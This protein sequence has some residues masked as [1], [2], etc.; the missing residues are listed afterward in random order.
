MPVGLTKYRDKLPHLRT[1]TAE[2]AGSIIDYIEARQ[3]QILAQTGTRFV[4]AADE[5]YV[6][7]DR[8]FPA[9][10][11]YEEMS[12]FENGIGMA[13]EFIT[14]FNRRR[15]RLS[16]LKADRKALF[17]TGHSAHPFLEREIMPYIRETLKLDLTFAPV[18]N[19]FWGHSVTVSGLLTGNDLLAFAQERIDN[20]DAVVLPFAVV[21]PAVGEGRVS[22][23]VPAAVQ[24]LPLVAAPVRAP[25]CPQT[26]HAVVA[27]VP[28]VG[29]ALRPPVHSTAVAYANDW[30]DTKK[31][32]SGL[33]LSGRPTFACASFTISRAMV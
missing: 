23:A 12:Q 18:P 31:M 27:P 30:S 24:P 28:V 16:G 13:R 29:I 7:A 15:T 20:V 4:W 3:H 22:P 19:E 26:V 32:L 14:M 33:K 2:E 9:R 6:I 1:Y 17:L 21:F 25:E 11:H 10:T 8:P 5:F